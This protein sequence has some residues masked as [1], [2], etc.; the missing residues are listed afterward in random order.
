VQTTY[1]SV[2]NPQ[3]KHL[4]EIIDD[5][6]K[7]LIRV[8]NFQR[9]YVWRQSDIISLF[10]SIY[11]G[12]PIGSL[13]LWETSQKIESF[14]S[15]GPFAIPITGRSEINYILDGHQRISTLFG[16]LF[17]TE[18]DVIDVDTSFWNL[19]F[20]LENEEFLFPNDSEGNVF[21]LPMNKIIST[22]SFLE[23]CQRIQKSSDN[24]AYLINKA[25][26]LAQSIITYKIAITQIK[27]GDLSSS[28]EIF[29]RLNTRGLVITPDQMLSAL[30]YKEGQNTF[31]LSD[32]IDQILEKLIEYHFSDIDRIFI[33]RSII[34]AA[35]RDIYKAKIE[36]LAK[37]K[38]VDLADI[39][40]KC[41]SSIVRAVSFLY[42]ELNVPGDKLLPYNLQLVFLSE[43]FF[44]CP[45]P[46]PSKRQEL[47]RWFWYTSYSG[48]FAGANS[49]K[50]K[51]G[52]D[53]IR[54][55]AKNNQLA[56]LNMDYSEYAVEFPDQF[57]FRYARVKTYILFLLSLNPRSLETGEVLD[58]KVLLSES[59][60]KALHYILSAPNNNANRLVLGP[61][62]YGYAK[63]ILQDTSLNLNKSTLE[64]H[65]ISSDALNAFRNGEFDNFL[66]LR[67]QKLEKMELD[68]MNRKGIKQSISFKRNPFQSQ[69]DIFSNS[70]E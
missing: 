51:I 48:W 64:S 34:A 4:T 40:A 29:S 33:F 45:E 5:I 49:S 58:A 27:G 50:I 13:L 55:F 56:L 53:N 24:S 32:K 42:N 46:N 66:N 9:P 3:V 20:D 26:K 11:K 14:P 19:Y 23:E 38:K 59:G 10:D 35:K 15:I 17:R 41:E 18:E 63:K 36:D 12:Y 62:K 28:V 16:V 39:S 1:S 47:E 52:L 44:N 8:P 54:E 60:N 57:D 37:D 30:T 67:Q 65:A 2:V 6:S 22:I 25:Q 68:F 43:F 7:G 69:L 61:V 21:L 31:K 70:K